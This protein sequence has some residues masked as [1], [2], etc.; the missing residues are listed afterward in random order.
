MYR[1][2]DEMNRRDDRTEYDRK[3]HD[4]R[5][6]NSCWRKFRKSKKRSKKQTD[7]STT[8]ADSTIPKQ[9]G[10]IQRW[11]QQRETSDS[12]KSKK[13]QQEYQEIEKL[14]NLLLKMRGIDAKNARRKT[15]YSSTGLGLGLHTGL[16]TGLGSPGL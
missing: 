12:S 6:K 8:A 7:P 4:D 15:K 5:K 3:H 13:T 9:P 11:L 14:K 10:S 1:M 2:E 16:H